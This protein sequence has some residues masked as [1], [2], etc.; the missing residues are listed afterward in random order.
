MVPIEKKKNV[1]GASQTKVRF[2]YMSLDAP[3]L[4]A[5]YIQQKI[6][7]DPQ[8]AYRQLK[9]FEASQAMGYGG[10]YGGQQGYGAQGYG[11]QG[12]WGGG[13]GGPPPGGMPSPYSGSNQP[14]A[15]AS[16]RQS[17]YGGG[18]GQGTPYGDSYGGSGGGY[19]NDGYG[20]AYG[21]GGYADA[22]GG[23]GGG[24]YAP[25]EPPLPASPSQGDLAQRL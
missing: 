12:G 2:T 1:F 3:N 7:T 13:Y 20:N 15:A 17:P 24:A 8:A 18:Y 10:G 25:D 5:A 6:S 19:A 14:S 11:G 4:D 23:G 21:E 16:P 22:Y 9:D